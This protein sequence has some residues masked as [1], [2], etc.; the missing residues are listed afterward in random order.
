MNRQVAQFSRS[1]KRRPRR[2]MRMTWPKAALIAAVCVALVV[3]AAIGVSRY[4]LAKL[5]RTYPL[6]YKD[7]IVRMADEF[8]LEPWHVA[9]VIRCESSFDPMAESNVG[10]RGLMQIMPDT[11]EWLAG[12][13]NEKDGYDPNSLYDPETNLKYG[14][15]YL[16]WLMSRYSGDV[17]LVAAAYHAGQGTVDTWLQN[18]DISSDGFTIPIES[19]PYK[20]TRDY[21]IKVMAAREKYEELYDFEPQEST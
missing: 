11:G 13:F 7:L 8:T 5:Y 16:N 17:V 19:I 15:W 4:N 6:R 20:S 10:A 1:K 21:V 3:G 2:R 12:K 18:A 14:C 9:A